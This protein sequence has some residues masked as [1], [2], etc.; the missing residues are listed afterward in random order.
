[1][2]TRARNGPAVDGPGRATAALWGRGRIRGFA[3][4]HRPAPVFLLL[5]LLHFKGARSRLSLVA[6]LARPSRLRR[7]LLFDSL[8]L[9]AQHRECPLSFG[10]VLLM[11]RSFGC[12]ARKDQHKQRALFIL[13][14]F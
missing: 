2:K 8:H 13:L 1:M 10:Q 11:A 4:R 5:L 7:R 14:H 6:Q 9:A 12:T 3:P